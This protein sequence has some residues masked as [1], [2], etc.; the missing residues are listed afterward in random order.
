MLEI[1]KKT[2]GKEMII[3]L[4]GSLDTTTSSNLEVVIQ[5]ELSNIETLIFDIIDLDYISSAGLRVMLL[6]QKIMNKQ[7]K[8]IVKNVSSKIMEIFEVTGFADA[9]T[10]E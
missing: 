3:G 9:L 5:S 4:A 7:G 8:M 2:N 6:A 10:I 1:K